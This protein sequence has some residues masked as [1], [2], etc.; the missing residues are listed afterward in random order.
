MQVLQDEAF[1]EFEFLT[2]DWIGYGYDKC[3]AVF[4]PV[5]SAVSGVGGADDLNPVFD[6]SVLDRILADLVFYKN[7][8][9][10]VGEGAFSFRGFSRV[11]FGNASEVGDEPF[12]VFS[13]LVVFFLG[14]WGESGERSVKCEGETSRVELGR[15]RPRSLATLWIVSAGIAN[16]I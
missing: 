9:E 15:P 10:D 4:Y 11:V 5:G 16:A 7:T 6:D 2:Y 8:V 12:D 3:S 1:V 13:K 14:H